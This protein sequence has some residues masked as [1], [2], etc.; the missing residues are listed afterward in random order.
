MEMPENHKPSYSPKPTILL[1][2]PKEW[3]LPLQGEPTMTS[4]E[5][6]AVANDARPALEMLHCLQAKNQDQISE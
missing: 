5:A 6:G 3:T 2:E 1:K 4:P